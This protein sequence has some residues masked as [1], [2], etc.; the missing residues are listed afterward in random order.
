MLSRK[1]RS[2]SILLNLFLPAPT[3][4]R[5]AECRSKDAVA[6]RHGKDAGE[7]MENNDLGPFRNTTV[8]AHGRIMIY[9]SRFAVGLAHLPGGGIN[10]LA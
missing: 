9:T 6:K 7:L 5:A 1:I 4:R 8:R 2:L 10:I 3:N